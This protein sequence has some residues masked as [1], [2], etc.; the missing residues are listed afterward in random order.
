M[1]IVIFA[2]HT[3]PD[4]ETGARKYDLGDLKEKDSIKAIMHLQQQS[5]KIELPAFMQRIVAISAITIM[6]NN[7]VINQNW[8]GENET[9]QSLLNQFFESIAESKSSELVS[10]DNTSDQPVLMYRC[11]KNKVKAAILKEATLTS[12]TEQL[13][14]HHPEA[15]T[16]QQNVMDMLG[17][18]H[19]P[20][21]S[22]QQ[23]WKHWRKAKYEAIQQSCVNQVSDCYKIYQRYQ[24]VMG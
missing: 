13:S 24:L 20:V 15:Q 19:S 1:S 23:I 10:W 22:T 21:L 7:Q 5:G 6:D 3:V 4:T 17:L 14:C 11:L 16:N 2:M 9:E 18:D 8:A 12:L